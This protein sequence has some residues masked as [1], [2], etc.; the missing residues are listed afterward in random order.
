MNVLSNSEEAARRHWGEKIRRDYDN[1]CT[2]GKLFIGIK[3]PRGKGFRQMTPKQCFANCQRVAVI[4]E[5][6]T[7]VEG[8]CV[9]PEMPNFTLRMLG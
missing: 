5:L 6:A 2:K 1:L 9:N 8:L 3:R 4:W 7:Y